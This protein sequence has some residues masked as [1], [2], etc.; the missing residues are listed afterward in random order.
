MNRDQF[1]RDLRKYCKANGLPLP[2][3]DSRRG[4]GGHAIIYVGTAFTTAPSGEL[5]RF[6]QEAMLKDLNLPKGAV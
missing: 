3:M 2:T 1:L 4:K 6:T 5:K